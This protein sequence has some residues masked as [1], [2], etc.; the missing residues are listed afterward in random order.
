MYHIAARTFYAQQDTKTPLYI[1]LFTITLN[2]VCPST[3]FDTVRLGAVWLAWAQSIVAVVEVAILF[4]ILQRK[5]PGI[6]NKHFR[7]AVVEM[8][9]ASRTYGYSDVYNTAVFAA[10]R[11]MTEGLLATLPKFV[12][13]TIVSFI[14]YVIISKKMKLD[15]TE[16]VVAR[17]SAIVFGKRR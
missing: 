6:F 11:L 5:T 17:V 13:I 3:V 2:I 15:E 7:V 9:V 10:A 12:V 1:S 8:L 16:P 14:V 4:V